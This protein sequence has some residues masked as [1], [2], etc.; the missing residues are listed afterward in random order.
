MR[1]DGVIGRRLSRAQAQEADAELV[2]IRAKHGRVTPRLIVNWAKPKSNPL[3]K[4]FEWDADRA[5]AQYRLRQAQQLVHAVRIVV[6]VP[7]RAQPY[8]TRAWVS[9]IDKFGRN[10]LPMMEAL[11]Q[12]QTRELVLAEAFQAMEQLVKRYRELVELAPVFEAIEK[13]L[14]R[15]K[16]AA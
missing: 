12:K 7:A 5:A 9:T 15:R 6:T 14:K 1:I 16:K 2:K 13:T 4:H 8:E 3:H 11:S 10:Y